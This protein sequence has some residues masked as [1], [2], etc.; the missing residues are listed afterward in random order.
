MQLVYQPTSNR[1]S[2]KFGEA[3][4]FD[5]M[6]NR[7]C[8]GKT[9]PYNPNIITFNLTMAQY[10]I[11]GRL[12]VST[13]FKYVT[14]STI[15]M[16]RWPKFTIYLPGGMAPPRMGWYRPEVGSLRG[17][18]ELLDLCLHHCFAHQLADANPGVVAWW[19]EGQ[20]INCKPWFDIRLTMVYCDCKRGCP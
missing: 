6:K 16:G 11:I 4:N 5:T 14:C 17:L 19:E 7:L 3:H 13:Y 20:Q 12:V 9:T 18:W 10:Q 2:Q 8:L 1:P 15:E